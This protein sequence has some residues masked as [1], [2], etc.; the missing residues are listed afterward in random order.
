MSDKFK[1]EEKQIEN[2]SMAVRKLTTIRLYAYIYIYLMTV[3]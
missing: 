3:D 2:T 1:K